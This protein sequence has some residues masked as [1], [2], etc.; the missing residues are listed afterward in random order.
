VVL[1]EV[2]VSNRLT[3]REALVSEV[4]NSRIFDLKVSCDI[5]VD[6]VDKVFVLNSE[7]F[8]LAVF[9]VFYLLLIED[10]KVITFGMCVF[11]NDVSNFSTGHSWG[12]GVN[13]GSGVV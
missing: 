1:A 3:E 6:Y 5:L 9:F 13:M 10:T 7:N 8:F 2:I 4:T 12:T 11:I